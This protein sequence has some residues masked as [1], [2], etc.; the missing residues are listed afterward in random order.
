MRFSFRPLYITLLCGLL[1]TSTLHAQ[2]QLGSKPMTNGQ[3]GSSGKSFD[4][5]EGT[6]VVVNGI[7]IYYEQYGEGEPILMIHDNGGS[8]A[9]FDGQISFLSR[10]FKVIVADSRGQGRSTNNADSLTYELMAEDYYLFL[11]QLQL[12]SVNILGWGDGGIVG[13]ILARD[14]PEKVKKLIMV[15]ARVQSDT[16]ALQAAVV[17]YT[18]MMFH[19]AEDSVAAGK[20]SF[21]TQEMLT[22]LMLHHPDI[23][24]ND[25]NNLQ[26]PVM[27]VA[28][29][30]DL[31]KVSHS[32]AIFENLPHAQLSIYPGA[33]HDLINEM[34]QLF[35]NSVM[36]FF[37]RPFVSRDPMSVM[38]PASGNNEEE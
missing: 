11:E 20:K 4:H 9:S 33:T 16:T 18:T 17:D 2:R 24:L 21:M 19:Q 6:Y 1:V 37:M 13:L 34:P 26:T 15:G 38:E 12:D 32:V 22:R 23:D 29:D 28:G 3:P 7:N 25:L 35:N 8:T 10:K 14:Y 30:R 27:V 31:V 5:I 36:R